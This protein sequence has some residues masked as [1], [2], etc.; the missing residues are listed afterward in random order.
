MEAFLQNA[1]YN[2]AVM[3]MTGFRKKLNHSES[4]KDEKI[5]KSK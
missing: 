3:N 1:C 4:G 2:R 5:H